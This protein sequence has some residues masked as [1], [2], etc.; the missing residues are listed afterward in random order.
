MKQAS[1]QWLAKL[2]GELKSLG[3]VQSKN[4]YSL[5]TKITSHHT[6]LIVVYVDE[7][8]ITGND[9]HE[10]TF[11]KQHLHHTFT[12]KDLGSLHYF[13]G[14]EISYSPQGLNLTQHKYTRS[15][16]KTVAS[17]HSPKWSPPCL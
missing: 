13:L 4:D 9:D 2:V 3:F 10:I 6:T 17:H 1:R 8:L 14:I 12:I 15:F 7:I 5:F 16:S 11:L